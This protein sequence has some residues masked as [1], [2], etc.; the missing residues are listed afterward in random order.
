MISAICPRSASGCGTTRP[1]AVASATVRPSA[2]PTP[3]AASARSA[4]PR[5]RASPSPP[6]SS[7]L[8][9]S[10]VIGLARSRMVRTALGLRTRLLARL[11]RRNRR[12]RQAHGGELVVAEADLEL[13]VGR[14]V[15]RV[16]EAQLER[17]A[18]LVRVVNGL[19]QR[20]AHVQRM[21]ERCDDM[22][23]LMHALEGMIHPYLHRRLLVAAQR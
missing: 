10:S 3:S 1:R 12:A 4:I 18:H 14:D 23:L 5:I 11:R 19:R 8:R 15:P 6:A 7:S 22:S 21:V 20:R 17:R 16:A 9:L 13:V 2:T